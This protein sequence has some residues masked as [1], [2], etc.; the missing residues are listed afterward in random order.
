MDFLR[1]RFRNMKTFSYHHFTDNGPDLWSDY[2]LKKKKTLNSVGFK[3]HTL[4]YVPWCTC[5]GPGIP[6]WLGWG[7]WS[8]MTFGKIYGHTI[9]PHTYIH[10]LCWF[11]HVISYAAKC[12]LLAADFRPQNNLLQN[13]QQLFFLCFWW[14]VIYFRIYICHVC[15]MGRNSLLYSGCALSIN[16]VPTRLCRVIYYHGDKKYPFLASGNRVKYHQL[17]I[18]NGT[19]FF[20]Q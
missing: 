11:V 7:H 19:S 14:W 5:A 17:P 6:Q 10:K 9:L 12:A 13:S 15:T 8:N 1:S 20:V 18:A 4:S 2:C 3:G 16:P